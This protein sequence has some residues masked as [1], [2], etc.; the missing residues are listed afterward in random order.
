MDECQTAGEII[1]GQV[2]EILSQLKA[3]EHALVDDILAG[4]GAD[5]EVFVLDALLYLLPYYI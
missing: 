4:E 1:V 5:I 3:G 2:G